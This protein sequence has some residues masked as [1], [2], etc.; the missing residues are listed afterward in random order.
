MYKIQDSLVINKPIDTVFEFFNTPK[1]LSL[2]TPSYMHFNLLTPDPIVMKEGAV[3]DYSITIMG[4]PIRW[5]S[6]IVDY[7]PPYSFVDIQL[8]G[9][10]SYW[11]HSHTFSRH[12]QGTLITDTVHLLMP[13]GI[14]G[15]FGYHLLAKHLNNALFS[16][17]KKV[18]FDYFQGH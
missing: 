5:T 11:H 15:K 17:R 7:D 13:F 10:H 6:L 18:V 12:D 2:I 3:F 9:P 1:N 14:V 16:H 4:L 8:Q